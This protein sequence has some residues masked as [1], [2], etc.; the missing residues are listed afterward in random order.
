LGDIPASSCSVSHAS[1]DIIVRELL[2]LEEEGR[3]ISNQVTGEIL[4]RVHEADDEGSSQVGALEEI[5]KG[6]CPAQLSFNFD[7]SFNHSKCIL[8]TLYGFTTQALDGAKSFLF[9]SAANE[10]PRGLGSEED[11]YQKWGLE[12]VSSRRSKARKKGLTGKSHCKARGNLQAQSSVRL[13]VP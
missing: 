12:E 1:L 4:R 9:A 2:T 5:E 3:L 10:P 11:D 7:G 8:I 6:R 13:L